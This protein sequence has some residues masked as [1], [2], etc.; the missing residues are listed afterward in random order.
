MGNVYK[1]SVM[2]LVATLSIK[3]T[4][5][6]LLPFYTYLISPREYGYVFMV[7]S[8][9]YFL[10]MIMS[11]SL[12]SAVARFYYDCNTKRKLRVLYSTI[13]WMITAI[14]FIVVITI[15][16]LD[17]FLSYSLN[18]P[19]LYLDI[20]L[21]SAYLNC[22]YDL[23]TSLLYA[24]QEAKKIS[25]TTTV[26]GILQICIQLTMVLSLNDKALSLILSQLICAGITFIIFLVYS[27]PYLSFEIDTSSVKL[28]LK[29][30][31]SQLPSD[32]S[33]W[34]LSLS[35]RMMLN[36]MK[37]STLTGIYG[38]GQTLGQIPG[39]AFSAINK[40]YVPFVMTCYKK[41]E[42]NEVGAPSE[43]SKHTTNIIS[44]TTMLFAL[45]ILFSNN[46]IKLLDER[47]LDSSTVMIVMLVS[48]LL[49]SYRKLFMNP[50]VYNIKYIKIKSFIWMLAAIMNISL[51]I[52]LIPKYS[53]YVAWFSMVTCY[54]VTFLLIIY[55]SNKAMKIKY[56]I[57][58]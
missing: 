51:N 8:V 6:L 30:S 15:L 9:Q 17:D 13:F 24:K 16:S 14:S 34:M 1:N 11:L 42:R 28:Y 2:Y 47:Y 10:S 56:E 18:I 58:K 41:I 46:I 55:Y 7:A 31:L 12:N 52:V 32:L 20:A 54:F 4:Q 29:Y 3:A 57:K 19:V 35:D 26:V 45:V 50:M 21:V 48:M 25:F 49:D 38:I 43:L 22:Y 53:I 33:V 37:G 39:I 27:K 40:A 23:I 36:K 44:I 5:F